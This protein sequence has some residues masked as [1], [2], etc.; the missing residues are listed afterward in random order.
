MFIK[1][2]FLCET[3]DRL[4]QLYSIGIPVESDDWDFTL[5]RF[6]SAIFTYL[7]AI[8]NNNI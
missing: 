6:I 8:R 3:V 7:V 2:W 1:L 5:S 4:I